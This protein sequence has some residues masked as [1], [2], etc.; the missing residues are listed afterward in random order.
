MKVLLLTDDLGNG[1]LERQLA[2][3]AK[4][5]PAQWDRRVF[6]LQ[7]G[8]FAAVLRDAGVPVDIHP[9][10]SRLDVR[11]ALRLW[12]VLHRWRPDIV[13]S[14][15]WMCSLAA[16]PACRALGIPMID[17]T[18]REGQPRRITRVKG[19]PGMWFAR[20]VVANSHAGLRACAIRGPKGL[21][22][23][24]G[25][26]TARLVLC[27]APQDRG[28]SPFTVVMTGHMTRQKDYRS[29]IAAAQILTQRDAK[30][31][32]FMAVGEGSDRVR[33][34][35]DAS[36]LT[37]S[38]V[39]RFVDGGLEVLPTVSRCHVGVL[40]TGPL[41]AEGCS[42]S[43]MEYMA[44][45]LPVVCSDGGGNRELVLDGVTGFVVTPGD[46]RAL[47]E[48]LEFLREHPDERRRLGIAGRR[49]LLEHFTVEQMVAGYTSLY[50]ELSAGRMAT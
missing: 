6:S 49:R 50:E 33:L 10:A 47:A 3:L 22:V 30:R 19:R 39:L 27:D 11:P 36:V 45:A 25:F 2:L 42:N 1:G 44:C 43:I 28:E 41:D 21:V 13:H 38:G 32:L 14:W 40:M 9:R 16:G 4:T 48:R 46:P 23:W 8:P 35:R 17:G 24:N 29:F 15:G 18:I 31:W 37:Q 12:Q 5:L 34:V 20:R 26:D 7:D